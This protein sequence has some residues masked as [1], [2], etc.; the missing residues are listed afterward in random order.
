MLDYKN[1]SSHLL[2]E[3]YLNPERVSLP[4]IDMDMNGLINKTN[5]INQIRK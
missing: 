5:L 4:D 3:R 2:F 1:T